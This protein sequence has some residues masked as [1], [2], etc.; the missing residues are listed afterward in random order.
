MFTTT[1]QKYDRYVTTSKKIRPLAV[2]YE[3]LERLQ[4][5]RHKFA[6][7]LPIY[8]SE[9]HN[10]AISYWPIFGPP[11]LFKIGRVAIFVQMVKIMDFGYIGRFSANLCL[12]TLKRSNS[13]PFRARGIIFLLVVIYLS[14]LYPAVINTWH[15]L[16]KIK[17]N[18]KTQNYWKIPAYSEGQFR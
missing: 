7:N 12:L 9:V 14:Y 15:W 6:E 10:L 3:K 5:K 8:I 4:V 16:Q 17:K 11:P 1:G 13:A 18:G 2:K